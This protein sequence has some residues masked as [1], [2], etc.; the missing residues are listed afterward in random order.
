MADLGAF[1]LYSRCTWCFRVQEHP[2]ALS[3]SLSRDC[4]GDVPC[5]TNNRTKVWT[6]PG[7][8]VFHSMIGVQKGKDSNTDPL[9]RPWY[10][11]SSHPFLPLYASPNKCKAKDAESWRLN[12][13]A[14][15]RSRGFARLLPLPPSKLAGEPLLPEGEPVKP[16]LGHG[17]TRGRLL[18]SIGQCDTA[19]EEVHP[20]LSHP[21]MGVQQR[22]PLAARARFP[23]LHPLIWTEEGGWIRQ[24]ALS[25]MSSKSL[26]YFFLRLNPSSLTHYRGSDARFFEL[27]SFDSEG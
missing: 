23:R 22:V 1:L 20:A 15:L 13:T 6:A 12:L 27:V 16:R 11:K 10:L 26:W 7:M 2:R 3:F 17:R 8:W 9:R 18:K 24:K 5:K 25:G 14:W 21:K 19:I 4:I